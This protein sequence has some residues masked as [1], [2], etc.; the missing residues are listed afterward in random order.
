MQDVE[1]QT[2]NRMGL[3]RLCAAH[4]CA[5]VQELL[6]AIAVRGWYTNNDIAKYEGNYASV[7]SSHC[8]ALGYEVAV[9]EVE[10][11]PPPAAPRGVEQAVHQSHLKG[12]RQHGD[13]LRA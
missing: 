12:I 7:F 1:W 2:A 4:D 10:P 3:A 9:A 5:G 13:E 6:Q 8:A 11:L